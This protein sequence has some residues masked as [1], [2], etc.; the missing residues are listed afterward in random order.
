MKGLIEY[1]DIENLPVG[2]IAAYI[3]AHSKLKYGDITYADLFFGSVPAIKLMDSTWEQHLFGY[4]AY[5]FFDDQIPVY[6]GKAVKNFKH[7]F[8]SHRFFDPRP[9]FGFNKLAQYLA[10]KKL[11]NSQYATDNKLFEK[12]ILPI[13]Y[14]LYVVRINL[15]GSPYTQSKSGRLENIVKKSINDAMPGMLYNG[16]SNISNYNPNY[17]LKDV[18]VK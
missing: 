15:F 1:S 2:E 14:E 18:I 6:V 7:R 11:G 4:G 8:E 3:A 13:F 10:Q 16:L 5:V 9:T 12:H 17:L